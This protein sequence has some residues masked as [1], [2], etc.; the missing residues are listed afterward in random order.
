MNFFKKITYFSVSKL[1][2]NNK[3]RLKNTHYQIIGDLSGAR[4]RTSTDY[5]GEEE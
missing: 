2:I 5:D 4:V 3:K 1:K